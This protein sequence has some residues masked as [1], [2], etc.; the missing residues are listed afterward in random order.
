VV[1][2]DDLTGP[3]ARR[4][5]SVDRVPGARQRAEVGRHLGLV[6]VAERDADLDRAERD[7]HDD[8]AGGQQPDRR[9]SPVPVHVPGSRC[10][11]ALPVTV[12]LGRYGPS[13]RTVTRTTAVA[14]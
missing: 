12:T 4:T 1:G 14:R 3:R 13:G 6:P 2:G 7:G 10:A 9:R 11:T 5:G 8:E